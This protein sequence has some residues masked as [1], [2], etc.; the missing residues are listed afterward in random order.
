MKKLV[1]ILIAFAF[2]FGTA[3]HESQNS[4]YTVPGIHA[5]AR[6]TFSHQTSTL[7][8]PASDLDDS[9]SQE[10][11]LTESLVKYVSKI[12]NGTIKTFRTVIFTPALYHPLIFDLPPPHFFA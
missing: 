9:D 3:F 8:Q 1:L 7:N 12:E 5:S 6:S 2:L 10:V 4:Q 11:E